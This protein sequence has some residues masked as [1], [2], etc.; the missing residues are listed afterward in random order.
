MQTKPRR[1]V[2]GFRPLTIVIGLLLLLVV[3]C[4]RSGLTTLRANRILPAA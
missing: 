1:T 4:I 2:A 3:G